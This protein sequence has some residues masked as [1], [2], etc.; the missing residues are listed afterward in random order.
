M[1]IPLLLSFGALCISIAVAAFAVWVYYSKFLHERI[2]DPDSHISPQSSRSGFSKEEIV[3]FIDEQIKK[4]APINK[5]DEITPDLW[6]KICNHTTDYVVSALKSDPSLLAECCKDFGSVNAVEQQSERRI[7]NHAVLY[8]T[9]ADEKSMEFFAVSETYDPKEPY[10][11]ELELGFDGQTATFKVCMQAKDMVLQTLDYLNGACSI[12]R[13]GRSEI[14]TEAKG[15][16]IL[17]NS[18]KWKVQ[19]PTKIILK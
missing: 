11:F 9:A 14:I 7:E 19:K 15:E 16:A 17:L 18:G 12:Q 8:A 3:K 6:E 1:T 2:I 5:I 10:V 4:R 13:V